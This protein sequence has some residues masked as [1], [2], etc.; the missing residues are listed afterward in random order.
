MSKIAGWL[1][2]GAAVLAMGCA[3]PGA[4]SG[5]GSTT[6]AYGSVLG[7]TR[8]SGGDIDGFLLDDNTHVHVPANSVNKISSVVFQGA[9]VTV[10]GRSGASGVDAEKITNAD[11]GASVMV[12]PAASASAGHAAGSASR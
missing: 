2:A 11:T 3:T 5:Q 4:S 8:G 10:D 12:A 1:S 6:S 9:R 7:F